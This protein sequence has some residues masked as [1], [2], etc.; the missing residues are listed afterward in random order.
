MEV[1]DFNGSISRD[2]HVVV[3]KWKT[4]FSQLLHPQLSENQNNLNDGYTN[5][6]SY[7]VEGMNDELSDRE[8][9]DAMKAMKNNKAYGVD[10]LPAE[11]VK[12][13]NLVQLLTRLFNKCVESGITPEIWKKG[14]IQPIPKSSM[15]DSRDPL[16]Y[17]GTPLIPVIYKMYCFI[18]NKRLSSW[19]EHNGVITDNENGFRKGRSTT[20]IH[21]NEHNRNKKVKET[22]NVCSFHRFQEGI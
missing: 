8:V 11:V 21:I 1:I 18:L 13:T 19:D 22:V 3:I 9:A 20:V 12:N 10:E 6:S 2:P 4:D 14:I 17:R 15:M 7:S 16:S 5:I